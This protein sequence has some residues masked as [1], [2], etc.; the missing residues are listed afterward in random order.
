MRHVMPWAGCERRQPRTASAAVPLITGWANDLA[1]F[2]RVG[3]VRTIVAGIALD[4]DPQLWRQ[5]ACTQDRVLARLIKRRSS[6]QRII[7][8][9]LVDPLSVALRPSP[10]SIVDE[11]NGIEDRESRHRRSAAAAMGVSE[12]RCNGGS[13][14]VIL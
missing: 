10:L 6:L 11:S 12:N 8:V 9:L 3:Q 13:A 5:M 1:G 2:D 4:L 7:Q 14:M